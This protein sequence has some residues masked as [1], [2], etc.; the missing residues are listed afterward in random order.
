MYFRSQACTEIPKEAAAKM[1]LPVWH[2]DM[3]VPTIDLTARLSRE[4]GLLEE[5]PDPGQADPRDRGGGTS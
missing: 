3:N 5:E 2:E 4:Y 1:K